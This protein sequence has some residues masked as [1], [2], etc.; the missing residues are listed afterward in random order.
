MASEVQ[1]RDGCGSC[2]SPSW[3]WESQSDSVGSDGHVRPGLPVDPDFSTGIRGPGRIELSRQRNG[4]HCSLPTYA[5]YL[6]P[7]SHV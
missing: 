5:L 2:L 7:L 6:V 4:V 3:M 1:S